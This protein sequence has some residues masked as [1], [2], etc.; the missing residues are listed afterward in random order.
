MGEKRGLSMAD[1]EGPIQK[2]QNDPAIM[3]TMALLMGP[4]P[5]SVASPSEKAKSIT[6]EKI[7][8]INAFMLSELQQFIKYFHSLAGKTTYDMK[9]VVAATQAM[10]DSKV[11][12]KFNV[13]TEDMEGAIMA[14]QN[15]L[16]RDAAFLETHQKIQETMQAFMQ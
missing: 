6:T 1:L 4:D 15:K 13:E 9:T 2:N 14:N 11:T 3:Q 16:V 8:E 10:L 12:A 7:T 5:N